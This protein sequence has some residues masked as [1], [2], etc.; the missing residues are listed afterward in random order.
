M[1]LKITIWCSDLTDF[2]KHV[3]DAVLMTRCLKEEFVDRAA[4]YLIYNK[5]TLLNWFS[6]TTGPFNI[7]LLSHYIFQD[8]TR[9][10]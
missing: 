1:G 10:N 8:S 2:L 3:K 7:H 6:K 9:F 4:F 5:Q